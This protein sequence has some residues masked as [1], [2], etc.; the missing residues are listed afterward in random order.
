M[1]LTASGPS[2]E[3]S[4]PPSSTFIGACGQSERDAQ[5]CARRSQL[6]TKTVVT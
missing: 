4:P 2:F 3:R 5:L 1:R 6:S